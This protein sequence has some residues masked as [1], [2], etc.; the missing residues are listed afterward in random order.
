MSEYLEFIATVFD[1]ELIK[2]C[3]VTPHAKEDSWSQMN[4]GR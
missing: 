1:I 4:Y 2:Q 3:N